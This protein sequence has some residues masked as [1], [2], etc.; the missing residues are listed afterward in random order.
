MSD[1][2]ER[3]HL[4]P[5]E[6]KPLYIRLLE[7]VEPIYQPWVSKAFQIL[8]ASRNHIKSPFSNSSPKDT[9]VSPLTISAFF[10]AINEDVNV[11]TLQGSARNLIQSKFEKKKTLGQITLPS[12][13]PIYDFDTPL[14]PA[15]STLQRK[16][17]DTLVQLTARCA[18]FLEVSITE[19]RVS[20]N[21]LV[22]YFHRTARDFLE[23]EEIWS[24]LLLQTSSTNFDP[25][26]AMMRSCVI[27]LQLEPILIEAK[28]PRD[29]RESILRVT[30]DCLI[31][32]HYA[33]AHY[34]SHGTQTALLDQLSYMLTLHDSRVSQCDNSGFRTRYDTQWIT[35]LIPTAGGFATFLRLAMLFDLKAYVREGINRQDK[36][37]RQK[38]AT[39]LLHYLL[40]SQDC[41]IY[42]NYLPLPGAEMV[43]F[44]LHMKADSNAGCGSISAWKSVLTYQANT[45][46]ESSCRSLRDTEY[47]EPALQKR[48]IE[49]MQLLVLSGADP[50][51]AVLDH[52]CVQLTAIEIVE[53]ILVPRFPLE[54]T[55][56]LKEL[57][58]KIQQISR[59]TKK[60]S[61]DEIEGN[62]KKMPPQKKARRK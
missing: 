51:A 55:P 57:R 6:L 17:E 11:A 3:L 29:D 61:Y 32:S 19:K 52:E 2:W 8:R 27:T 62:S 48:Y 43:R 54:A 5:R 23:T 25:N 38:L 30:K 14:T 28:E 26:T 12:F 50:E 40:P 35:D 22:R 7:L 21:S 13:L 49:I 4:M 20:R 37:Q 60:K 34:Q 1:L 47:D 39:S 42:R 15:S 31:Y 33:D 58:E 10:F 59:S 46:H 18:G 56:L 45:A 41:Y 24:K 53:N 16:C 44:L 36:S 9:G